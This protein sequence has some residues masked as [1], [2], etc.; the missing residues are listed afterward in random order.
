LGKLGIWE[1][2]KWLVVFVFFTVILLA[3][4]QLAVFAEPENT[5]VIWNVF[6]GGFSELTINDPDGI[7]SIERVDFDITFH[8]CQT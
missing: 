8:G 7:A 2:N 5:E 6:N 4:N 1:L 3:G